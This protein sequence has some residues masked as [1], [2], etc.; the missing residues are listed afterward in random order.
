VRRRTPP[1]QAR[2]GPEI[3]HRLAVPVVEDHVRPFER[4][5]TPRGASLLP[6]PPDEDP[7]TAQAWAVAYVR[8][9]AEV[10]A[11]W[12]DH[13]NADTIQ[14]YALTGR[15]EWRDRPGF[16]RAARRERW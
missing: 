3:P 16:A 5:E 15:P 6:A 13:P 7:T 9:S 14:V 8:W 10:D 12:H 4:L 11:W 1:P 2:T